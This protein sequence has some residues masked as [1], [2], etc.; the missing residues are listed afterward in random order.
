[1]I[2]IFFFMILS[3]IYIFYGCVH[4]HAH[5]L[6]IYIYFSKDGQFFLI[7]PE[8]KQKQARNSMEQVSNSAPT[9]FDV[10][11]LAGVSRGTVDRVVYGRGRVSEETKKKV[12]K[13][14]AQLN[15]SPN[16]NASSLSK[17]K[18]YRFACLIPE[19]KEGE[20]WEEIHKGFIEGAG[21]ITLGSIKLDIYRYDQTDVD[22]FISASKEIIESK[23]AGVITNT[24]FKDA[25]ID[26]AEALTSNNIPYAFVDNKIDNLEYLLYYGADPYKSGS[27]GAFL[28]T[29][30]CNVREI[31]LIRLIRDAK[32]KADPNAQRRKGFLDYIKEQFPECVVHTVFIYQDNPEKNLEILMEFFDAH[33]EIKH[34]A[35][36]NSR[37]WLIDEY[38]EK[39]PDP[40][41]IVVGFDDLKR[42]LECLKK[43]H[44]EYLVTRHIPL[45]AYKVMTEF[46][47]CVIKNI[48]PSRRNNYVHMDILHRRN[49]D[50]Y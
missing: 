6:Q 50:D 23:P 26:F 7:L 45:Q 32:H 48:R 47:E 10:A 3:I 44:I 49:L 11:K 24:V 40:D 27:L 33:P 25:V 15:Y 38:L 19:F 43:G 20:Y 5:N 35:M 8:V 28:L 46:A 42:N 4:V 30:R 1:M 22:S 18:E 13:A 17:R 2:V 31:A 12:E 21:A 9:I 36:A 39:Y 41:R 29:T 34:V 37:V 14:I 16:P